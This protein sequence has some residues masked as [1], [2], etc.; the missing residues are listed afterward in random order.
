MPERHFQNWPNP[1]LAQ[2]MRRLDSKTKLFD[3]EDFVY[4]SAIA[5]YL[6]A[7]KWYL[8]IYLIGLL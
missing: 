7:I 5:V 8:N 6:S 4:E 3:S 2:W 1:I